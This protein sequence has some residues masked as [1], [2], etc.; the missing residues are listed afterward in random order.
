[1]NVETWKKVDTLF[2]QA[3]D[4]SPLE[5]EEFLR[6][7]C[8]GDNEIRQAVLDMLKA[9]EDADFLEA[10][11]VQALNETAFSEKFI[12]KQIGRFK[13][14]HE[15]GQGG[16]GAVFAAVRTD[17]IQ[18]KVALKIL[19]HSF[20]SQ[21]LLDR[22]RQEQQILSSLEHP[23]IARLI[24]AGTTADGLPFLAMEFVEGKSIDEYCREQ[25]LRPKEILELFRTV[26]SAV[27]YAHQHLV[28]HR[29]LK[30]S[31]IIVSAE[32]AVKLLDFGIAKLLT[33][34][35]DNV[36]QT[37]QVMMT[38]AYASPEQAKGENITTVTD[39]YS[40][41]V[42]L[43]E[44]LTGER[45][46]NFE[47]KTDEPKSRSTK[48]NILRGEVRN[49]VAM[50]LRAERE[51]RYV[52]VEQF[53]EDIRR[54]LNGLP[55]IARPDTFSYRA[56][57]FYQR[58][59]IA[60]A[61]G[62]I[63]VIALLGG[64]IA[65]TWQARIARRERAIAE[66]RFSDVRTLAHNVIF[67]Y[68]DAIEDLP[69]S[70]AVR[71]MLV[72]DATNYLDSLTQETNN[73][74]ALEHELALAYQKIGDVQGETFGPNL[75]KSAAAAESYKKSVALLE[76]IIPSNNKDTKLG[77]DLQLGYNKLGLL[78]VRQNLGAE[79]F[80]VAQKSIAAGEQILQ[81]EPQ[82]IEA[83]AILGRGRL[84]SGD[85]QKLTGGYE[86]QTQSYRETIA[87]LS[88]LS[89]ATKEIDKIRMV[90]VTIK[91]RLGTA[92]EDWGEKLKTE[93]ATAEAQ[94]KFLEAIELH[95]QT[96]SIMETLSKRYPNNPRYHRNTGST[97]M[98][99][100]SAL[101][102]AGFAAESLPHFQRALSIMKEFSAMDKNNIEAQR[103]VAEALQY[104]A[105]GFE[106]NKQRK[107]ALT[108][109][110]AARAILAAILPKDPTNHEFLEQQEL[111]QKRIAELSK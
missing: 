59:K 99:V 57:K 58:N 45:P 104:L 61:A 36:T 37:A 69:G 23:N 52:S 91:Q 33:N 8:N 20:P 97:V 18:Q 10:S 41:G 73:D 98:N 81:R 47:T 29:D 107:E 84:V 101:A 44:L 60:V 6:A 31:N 19:R 108:N 25:N 53:S 4:I 93:N 11:P 86:K 54:Y 26:C 2:N 30:P 9:D 16:M 95:R 83:I 110:Q 3:L 87:W 14:L 38:P 21:A 1:M 111:I 42:I 46:Q 90:E 79:A 109:Y 85:A 62:I 103:D 105:M 68:H 82:N 78:L 75:G 100:G 80:A 71:E 65:T 22:F 66:Q 63:A 13:I 28:I 77:I 74:V 67:K 96:M 72:K 17:E 76:K 15:I 55:I 43:H 56:S 92:L 40:L 64:I 88:S 70:T 94:A 7:S 32:G 49:I 5:R 39:I 24:D 89:A 106:K 34:E 48:Q 27:S 51:R 12:G 35:A 102:R 50:A